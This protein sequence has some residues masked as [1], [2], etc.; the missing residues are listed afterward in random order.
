MD[1]LTDTTVA[2]KKEGLFLRMKKS[3]SGALA[4]RKTRRELIFYDLAVFTVAFLFSRS[5]LIFGAYPL[6]VAFLAVLPSFVWQALIGA[7]VGAF[8]LGE[9][10][11]IYAM[12]SVVVVFLRVVVSGTDKSGGA[13][14]RL[15]C[16][17]LLLRMCSAI[18]GGF[19]AAVYEA[20][21]S[22]FSTATVMFGLSM[23]LLPPVICFSVSGIF[24]AGISF[25]AIF[26]SSEA[27]FSLSGVKDKE[28][29]NIIFFQFSS[30]VMIFLISLSLMQY[31]L[32]GIGAAYVFSSSA[33]LIVA[34]RFGALRA[35][36]VGFVSSVGISGVF[37]VS[38]ALV[39]LVAG[40]L[41]KLGTVYAVVGAGAALA[42][43][44][45]YTGG[46]T[47]FVSTFPEYAI[48]ASLTFFLL[49][50]IPS[51]ASV[52][53]EENGEKIASEMVGTMAL[54][55]RNRYSGSLDALEASFSAL[56]VVM[57]KHRR[58]RK[59]NLPGEYTSLA[60]RCA[61]E[62]LM[63]EGIFDFEADFT[64]IGELLASGSRVG[65]GDIS[66]LIEDRRRREALASAINRAAALYAE[67]QYKAEE[68]G[69][70]PMDFDLVARLISDARRN[71]ER[72]KSQDEAT[73][74]KIKDILLSFGLRDGAVR[75]LGKRK[76][77]IIIAGED[78]DGT[79]IT[80]KS[81]LEAIEG[82]VGT[83]L[84]APE[85]FRRGS[86]ALMECS[87]EPQY[88][89]ES[90]TASA[91]GARERV[92][93]D[94]SRSFV[95]EDGRF[96]SVIS[97]GM[98]SGEEAREVAEFVADF[99]SRALEFGSS[100]ES[101]LKVLN[102]AMLRR[103]GECSAT[104]DLFSFDLYTGESGFIK[105][106]AA[107]SYLKRGSSIFRIRSRTAPIGLMRE[108][109]AERVKVEAVCEDYVIMLS[110]GIS[111][112]SEDSPWLIELLSRP[113]KRTLADYAD[114]I[115]SSALLHTEKEN[116]D[117]MTVTV[118]K[119]SKK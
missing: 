83:S 114:H 7:V 9:A 104:V 16:E 85:Y 43:F 37:S 34:R 1:K 109:D 6:S 33:A 12:I 29:Y 116:R 92:S 57:K 40:A 25:G 20:L 48:S 61:E 119:I 89:V 19:I 39:G 107:P 14:A 11:I 103:E 67:E 106:G 4:E 90:A 62:Y 2:N 3:L 28:K 55:Y 110:D 46:V 51:E 78:P 99:L 24:D 112:S 13:E 84:T 15:F 87:C 108:L 68:R 88:K 117:D 36:A 47:G 70:I 96:F 21:L 58:K 63:G 44:S 8:T 80:S 17:G 77:R 56:S 41:M 100:R 118:I 81:F 10:G 38:F 74:E 60:K 95:S 94:V 22:G 105:S 59:E 97:D 69:G 93:G 79:R 101:V 45:G 91:S 53:N 31:S 27:I 30:L 26:R 111:Q 52:E 50:K 86:I 35:M 82:I 32:L 73:S 66:P 102:Q 23:L 49:G 64:N 98:G 115:L 75:V 5:H 76:K 113:P 54:S 18:I 72:E 71:D 65:E 42:L